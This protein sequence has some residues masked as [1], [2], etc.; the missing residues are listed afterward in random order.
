MRINRYSILAFTMGILPACSVPSSA[1]PMADF[2]T[3]TPAKVT[4]ADVPVGTPNSADQVAAI[5][6]M[7]DLIGLPDLI[8]EFIETTTMINSPN[9]D[10]TVMLYRDSM[11]RKYMVDP[12]TNRVVEVDARD[13]LSS[14]SSSGTSLTQTE[15]RNKAEKLVAATTEDFDAIN[16]ELSYEEGVKGDL[17]FF[18]WLDQSSSGGQ[19]QPINRPFAQVGLHVSGELVAYYN[20]LILG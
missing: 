5:Q 7:M 16:D 10:L 6:S 9:G 2:A 20:T 14:F 3:A 15:L 17:Y 8:L 11:G 1:Q 19:N 13:L 18:N 4:F 12:N